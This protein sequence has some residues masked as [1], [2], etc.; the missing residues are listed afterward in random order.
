MIAQIKRPSVS[1]EVSRSD[2]TAPPIR[3]PGIHE[4]SATIGMEKRVV[5]GIGTPIKT[6]TI[7]RINKIHNDNF[8]VQLKLFPQGASSRK[9]KTTAATTVTQLIVK[10]VESKRI[11]AKTKSPAQIHQVNGCSGSFFITTS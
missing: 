4:G 2:V 6:P 10:I 1:A 11:M 8:R 7:V 9:K 5:P 3:I